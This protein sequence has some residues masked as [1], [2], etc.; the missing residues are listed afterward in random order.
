MTP[1]LRAGQWQASPAASA[2]PDEYVGSRADWACCF[3]DIAWTLRRHSFGCA[4]A[5]RT[6]FQAVHSSLSRWLPLLPNSRAA[7]I[8]YITS[9]GL[10]GMVSRKQAWLGTAEPAHRRVQGGGNPF[11]DMGALMENVKKV[12]CDRQPHLRS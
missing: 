3:C 10:G 4:L 7:D 2:V 11:G 8:V 6:V 12:S 9:S 5:S 1:P